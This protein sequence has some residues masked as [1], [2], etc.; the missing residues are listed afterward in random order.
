MIRLQFTVDLDYD[1]LQA[2]PY[3]LQVRG[4]R[5]QRQRVVSEILTTQPQ[6]QFTEYVDR[7]TGTRATRLLAPLGHLVVHYEATVDVDHYLADPREINE[8]PV[9]RMPES[10]LPYLR[11]SRY[12]QSDRLHN[13][14]LWEFG[15]LPRG[16]ARA[17]AIRQWVHR[18][19]RFEAGSSHVGTSALD[20]LVEQRGVCRDYVHLMIAYCRALSIPARFVTGIDYGADPTLG[21]PDFHS[22]VECYLGGRWYLFDP[23][24]ISPLTGLVRIATGRDAAD[25]AFAA[26]FGQV[27]WK[28]PRVRIDVV[29]DPAQNLQPAVHT[30][31]AVS[32]ADDEPELEG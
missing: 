5:T 16:F 32:T 18:R 6:L 30:D 11:P 10:V 17:D 23:S 19:T 3:V 1:L 2:S 25:V 20:T 22:Y 28:M 7:D 13:S 14:A 24:G 31:L 9:E 4:A 21:P 26:V 12:C 27:Q 8:T 29:T 15:K